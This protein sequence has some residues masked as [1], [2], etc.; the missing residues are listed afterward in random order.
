MPKDGQAKKMDSSMK[1]I[2]DYPG[3]K[4]AFDQLA[5]DKVDQRMLQNLLTLRRILGDAGAS[6]ISLPF[7]RMLDGVSS[8]LSALATQLTDLERYPGII[9]EFFA[10]AATFVRIDRRVDALPPRVR[11]PALLCEY[12]RILERA[13][14]ERFPQLESTP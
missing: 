9:T 7:R 6:R 13:R 1:D 5:H 11:L 12:A 8:K 10:L 4:E 3:A 14:S 2:L